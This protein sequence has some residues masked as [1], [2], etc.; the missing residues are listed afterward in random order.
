LLDCFILQLG[1]DGVVGPIVAPLL[2]DDGYVSPDFDLPDRSSVDDS[3]DN[4][5][6]PPRKRTK[7]SSRPT[8]NPPFRSV[9]NSIEDDEELALQLLRKR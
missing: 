4:A 1:D 9:G 2:D 3:E 5:A 6:T 7:T 8:K